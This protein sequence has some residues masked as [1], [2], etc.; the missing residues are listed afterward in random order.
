MNAAK[1]LFKNEYLDF[2]VSRAY[3][4]AF[5]A[6]RALLLNNDIETSKHSGVIA[7]IHQHFVKTEKLPVEQ[8]KNLNWLFELRSIGDYGG[9]FHVE[10][11]EAERALKVAEEFVEAIKQLIE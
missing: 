10:R 1:D 4:A 8:G 7:L 5:Y 9:M 3:Y 6:S 11:G 2:S